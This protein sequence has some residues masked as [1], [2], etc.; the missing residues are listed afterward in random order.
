MKSLMIAIACVGALSTASAFAHSAPQS[1]AAQ[2]AATQLAS[3]S[4]PSASQAGQ[5]VAPYGQPTAEKTRAQ[6]YHELVKAE[7]DG[8]LA[9]LD[10]T[11]YAH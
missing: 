2:T 3:V 1:P 4:A 9:Y 6:V 7:K 11:L 10:S 5:W 8:Q